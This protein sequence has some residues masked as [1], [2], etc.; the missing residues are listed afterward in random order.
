[1][2]ILLTG[3]SGFIGSHFIDYCSGLHEI[4][5]C[6]LMIGLPVEKLSIQDIERV[7]AVV[8]LAAET[9]VWNEDLNK[10]VQH[11]ICA[12]VH[13]FSICKSLNKRFI[14]ASISCSY[15]ITSLYGLSKNFDDEFV[16]LYDYGNVVGLRFHNVYGPNPRKDTLFAKCLE[17]KVV[18]WNNGLNYRH[19]TYIDDICEAIHRALTCKNGLYNV[20]NPEEISTIAFAQEC[21]KYKPLIIECKNEKRPLDKMNQ[22]VDLSLPDIL[23]GKYINTELG[24][25]K[26]FIGK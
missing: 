24:L 3:S 21:S 9:S 13:L 15:N 18:L 14:Y 10:I 19:F 8:H 5:C 16:R 4:K 6:D 20:C 2:K 17:E 26:S 23:N 7:D 25:W 12:F 11:N 1:M 22:N